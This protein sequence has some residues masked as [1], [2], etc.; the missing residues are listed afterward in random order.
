MQPHPYQNLHWYPLT[1]TKTI[2]P[3]ISVAYFTKWFQS[4]FI[5]VGWRMHPFNLPLLV[6]AYIP[7]QS[8]EKASFWSLKPAGARNYKP[9]PGSSPTLIF[10]ARFRPESQICRGIQDMRNC[11]VT[12]N[13]VF[14]YRWKYTVYHTQN[15]KHLDQTIGIIWHKRSMLLKDNTAEYNVSQEKKETITKLSTMAL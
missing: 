12:K 9:E 6:P 5:V 14:G 15:S 8:C 1:S 3:K 7:T 2:W 10:E 11:G 4:A 13:V